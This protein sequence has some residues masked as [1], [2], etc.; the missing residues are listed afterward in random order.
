MSLIKCSECGKEISDKAPA[1]P[2]CGNPLNVAVTTNS[3]PV[4]IE[5][6]SKKWKKKRVWTVLVFI[7]GLMILTRSIGWGIFIILLAI[8]M[9][10]YVNIGSWWSNG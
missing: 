8:A 3:K 6:T 9:A 10:T 1:C 2:M 7:F 5:R 4:E